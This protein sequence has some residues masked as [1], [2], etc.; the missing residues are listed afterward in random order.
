MKNTFKTFYLVKYINESIKN[1]FIT[2]LKELF[3]SLE[4]F[5]DIKD[6][7][8]IFIDGDI[9]IDIKESLQSLMQDFDNQLSILEGFRIDT[10]RIEKDINTIKSIFDKFSKNNYLTMADLINNTSKEDLKMI[11]PIL[12]KPFS[13]DNILKEVI[14]GM[15]N[16]NLNVSKTAAAV[17]MHRNSINNKL[18]II[19]KETGLNIQKFYD[20][21]AMYELFKR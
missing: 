1:D 9:T 16:N 3:E 21:V 4:I 14:F 17:Y 18:D 7:T 13:K 19:E 2:T 8:I 12:L 10:L 20:A 5:V 15:F 6:S 11:K